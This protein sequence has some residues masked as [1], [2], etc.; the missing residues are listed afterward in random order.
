LPVVPEPEVPLAAWSA[1][2]QP[3][4]VT[5]CDWV[6]LADWP[7]LLDACDPLVGGVV[8]AAPTPAASTAANTVLMTIVR[9]I[10]V[11]S[12][13]SRERKRMPT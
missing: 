3:V 4:S 6:P 13:G 5:F 11:S 8:C 12:W 9:L 2:T 10:V 1:S 7:D